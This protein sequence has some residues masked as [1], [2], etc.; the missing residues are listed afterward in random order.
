VR[1]HLLSPFTP[2]IFPQLERAWLK[3]ITG[4]KVNDGTPLSREQVS[5]L[6]G[7]YHKSVGKLTPRRWNLILEKCH[8]YNLQDAPVPTTASTME[9]NRHQ[10]FIPSSPQVR[11]NIL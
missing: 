8:A 11:R 9:A 7:D 3:H 4:S 1:A 2:N 10:L 5:T 6:F